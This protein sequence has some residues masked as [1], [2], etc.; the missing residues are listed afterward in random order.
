ME[1]GRD[2]SGLQ[3]MGVEMKPPAK[4]VVPKAG[5]IRKQS[6]VGCAELTACGI[7]FGPCKLYGKLLVYGVVVVYVDVGG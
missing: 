1:F 5:G 7:V 6:V 3:V 4:V 2:A